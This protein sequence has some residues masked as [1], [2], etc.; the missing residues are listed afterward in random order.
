M[1]SSISIYL[2]DFGGTLLDYLS[3]ILRDYVTNN[4]CNNKEKQIFSGLKI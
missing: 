4:S 1:W 3:R 2:K